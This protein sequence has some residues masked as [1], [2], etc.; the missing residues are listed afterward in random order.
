MKKKYSGKKLLVLGSNTGASEIVKYARKNG[1]YTIVTDYLSPEQSP[2]KKISDEYLNIST[3]DFD[4]LKELVIK[5]R[6]DGILSGVSE[7]NILKAMRLSECCGLRF[8]CNENQWSQIN[9]KASFRELC[10]K[11]G[12]PS[13]KTYYMGNCPEELA[14][15]DFAYP[16]IV[17]PVDS[18]SSFGVFICN[19]KNELMS[20]SKQSIEISSK[21]EIIVEEFASGYEFSAHYT[22]CNG[23]VSLCSVDNRY[24]VALNPGNVTTIPI[25]RI[26][27]SLFTDSYINNADT[28]VKAL[29]SSLGLENA[30]LF[31]QGIY[32]PEVGK[33]YIFEAGLRPAGEYPCRFLKYVN[34]LDFT[35]ILVDNAL[36]GYV[37]ED[38]NVIAEDPFLQGECCG[39]VSYAACRG[40]IGEVSGLE[41][42]SSIKELLSCELRYNKGASIPS[43]NTLRQIVLRFVLRCSDRQNMFNTIR[44]INSNVDI[45]DDKG[46][47]ISVKFAPERIFGLQ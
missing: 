41:K 35:Q 30:V 33:F 12:V 11:Y 32:N 47:N 9:D 40:T 25:A 27:P 46:Q 17:K 28:P 26:Y 36:L 22:V 13:P 39:I 42:L 14:N 15:I 45:L 43:G 37:A 38:Y 18:S 7:F 4:I 29:I 5:Q 2:A 23:I 21:R 31:V 10:Q 6:I 24:P 8:Y 16:V 34:G 20:L 1:C 44:N 19:D 3:G